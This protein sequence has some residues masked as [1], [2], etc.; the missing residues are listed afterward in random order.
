MRNLTE[1]T[2]TEAV[3][4]SMKDAQDARTRE[5]LTS[6][7]RHLH[8]FIRDV[9]LTE[10]EWQA[11]IRFLTAS[12]Q[13]SDDNRQEIALLSDTLGATAM[14]DFINHR[15][16]PGATEHT[17]LG[18]SYRAGSPELPLGADIA[19]GLYGDPLLVSGHVRGPANEPL[20]GALLD[21]WQASGEG[22]YD[23]QGQGL[24]GRFRTDAEG[25]FH[26]RTIRPSAYPI[27]YDGPVGQMLIATGRHA[28][29]PAHIHFI[30]SA[31]GYDPVTTELYAEGDPY[32]DSD[33]VFGVRETLIVPF[34]RH[35]DP[36]EADAAGV[37][38]PFYTVSYEFVLEP[39]S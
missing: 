8:A 9:R 35:S 22:F 23:V 32:L 21:V 30:V 25:A 39:E 17:I 37:R 26:F 31:E 24:R 29:Q 15:H 5:V 14:K 6:L 10:E 28:F 36:A 20:E 27:P 1:T 33:A 2:L 13:L 18:P 34:I 4:D 11:G 16:A 38:A 7:V 12:G 3:V 19:E